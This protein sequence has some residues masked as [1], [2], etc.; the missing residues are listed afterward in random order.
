M[1]EGANFRMKMQQV[2]KI[3]ENEQRRIGIYPKTED[4]VPKDTVHNMTYCKDWVAKN[5]GNIASKKFSL[6][7]SDFIHDDVTSSSLADVTSVSRNVPKEK[8]EQYFYSKRRP[9]NKTQQPPK[10]ND[11][12]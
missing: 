8:K 11:R 3:K 2:E 5:S 10:K 1:K 9:E 6:A 4:K 7:Q 12:V